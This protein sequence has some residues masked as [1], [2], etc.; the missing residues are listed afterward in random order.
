MQD[1]VN[2]TLIVKPVSIQLWQYAESCRERAFLSF[3]QLLDTVSFSCV[4]SSKGGF[5]PCVWFPKLGSGR[6]ASCHFEAVWRALTRNTEVTDFAVAVLFYC[7]ITTVWCGL[8]RNASGHL[9]CLT[10][11]LL[12]V[13]CKR[14]KLSTTCCLSRLFLTVWKVKTMSHNTLFTLEQL[15]STQAIRISIQFI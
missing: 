5:G 13:D 6:L 9:T 15:K 14:Y 7:P 4:P 8:R 2:F 3:E 11:R 1:L 10:V 12:P